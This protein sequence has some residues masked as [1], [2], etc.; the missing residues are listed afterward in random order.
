MT[1]RHFCD[2]CNKEDPGEFTN[3]QLTSFKSTDGGDR[4]AFGDGEFCAECLPLVTRALRGVL[5]QQKQ[6]GEA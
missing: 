2:R 4:I 1:Q 3:V 6:Q 5:Y